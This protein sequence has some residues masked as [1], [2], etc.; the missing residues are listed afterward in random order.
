M[1]WEIICEHGSLRTLT[2]VA[3]N[4]LE[5]SSAGHI[6][7]A[8]AT[9][10]GGTIDLFAAMAMTRFAGHYGCTFCRTSSTELGTIVATACFRPVALFAIA[11]TTVVED[12]YGTFNMPIVRFEARAL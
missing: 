2:C 7:I 5:L 10:V 11:P 3:S 6:V 12:L 1:D 4:V 9:V 8:H